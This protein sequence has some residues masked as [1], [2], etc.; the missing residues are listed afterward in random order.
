MDKDSQKPSTT[1]I[2]VIAIVAAAGLAFAIAIASIPA[3]LAQES[4][5]GSGFGTIKFQ[6]GAGMPREFFADIFFRAQTTVVA[7]ESILTGSFSACNA[8]GIQCTRGEVTEGKIGQGSY[9]LKGTGLQ[10]VSEIEPPSPACEEGSRG[11]DFILYGKCGEDVSITLLAPSNIRLAAQ[12][13][14][15]CTN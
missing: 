5:S 1:S 6:S 10:F 7:G 12:G 14:V 13:D 15:L 3:A 9:M 4:V 8:D 11:C 2:A